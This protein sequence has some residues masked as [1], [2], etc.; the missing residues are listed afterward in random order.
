MQ[1]IYAAQFEQLLYTDD[2]TNKRPRRNP[3]QQTQRH[4]KQLQNQQ[5]IDSIMKHLNDNELAHGAE[6]GGIG[7]R[8]ILFMALRMQIQSATVATRRKQPVFGYRR[9]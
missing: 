4:D 1:M 3:R 9:G 7:L 2:D 5:D 8:S 6:N